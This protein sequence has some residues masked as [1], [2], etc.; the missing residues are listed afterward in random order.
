MATVQWV[1]FYA[2]TD[3]Q[4]WCQVEENCFNIAEDILDFVICFLLGTTDD[5]ISFYKYTKTLISSEIVI[6]DI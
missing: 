2:L 6:G 3:E 4:Y 1:S 5:V